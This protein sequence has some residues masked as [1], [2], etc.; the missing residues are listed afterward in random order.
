M[1]FSN[2]PRKVL[3]AFS[4]TP[5]ADLHQFSYHESIRTTRKGGASV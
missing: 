5:L 3:Q 1:S 4:F 2:S